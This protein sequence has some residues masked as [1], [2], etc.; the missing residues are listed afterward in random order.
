M[1]AKGNRITGKVFYGNR[2]LTGFAVELCG[3]RKPDCKGKFIGS[4]CLL[5]SPLLDVRPKVL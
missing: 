3:H 5:E 1:A 4:H 2:H